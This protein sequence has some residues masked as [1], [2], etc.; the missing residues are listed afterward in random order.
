MKY[1]W[2][3]AC[4]FFGLP[5][6]A[7]DSET[8]RSNIEQPRPYGYV[9]GDIVEQTIILEAPSSYGIDIE[10][11]PKI[12]RVNGW[13]ERRLADQRQSA[14]R[15]GKRHEIRL[16]YQLMKAPTEVTMVPLPELAIT[17]SDAGKPVN[18]HIPAWP[19]TVAPLT[20]EFVLA[21]DGLE[22]MRPSAPAPLI[23]TGGLSMRVASYVVGL[24]LIFLYA[25]YRRFGV[26]FLARNNGPFA[27]ALR[28]L[29]RR[30]PTGDAMQALHRAF[31]E[32]AGAS[33]VTSSLETFLRTHPQ[34]ANHGNA[35]REF[36]HR[37]ERQFFAAGEIQ[38]DT[39]HSD[40]LELC[41]TLR[42][43]ERGI[44]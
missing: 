15:H 44:A 23:P 37:S 24:S 20:P 42:D 28:R 18:H 35:I 31:D 16:R 13:L 25:L 1:W 9:V 39:V 29:R 10:S 6:Q 36:F 30:G 40:L 8:I 32:T 5:L 22:E 14:S 11:L 12:G 21:S 43:I 34:F 4:L 3:V 27:R 2:V 41:A 19:V 7:Q 26:P 33:V 38:G 17:F